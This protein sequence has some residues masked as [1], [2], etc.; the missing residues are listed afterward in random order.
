M[1]RQNTGSIRSRGKDKW[2]VSISS[3]HGNRIFETVTGTKADAELRAAE[4]IVE[5]ARG[6]SIAELMESG[7][8]KEPEPA[9]TLS[10]YWHD[11]NTVSGA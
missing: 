2:E 5:D 3:R 1:P 7:A 4:M 6:V 11:D 8:N 10:D 9:L